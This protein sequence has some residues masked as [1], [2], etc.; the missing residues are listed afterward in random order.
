MNKFKSPGIIKGKITE[1]KM[2][3]YQELLMNP[4]K[5]KIEGKP[6]EVKIDLISCMCDNK[7]RWTIKKN[8]EGDYKINT[9]GYAYSNWQIDYYRDDIEW[10]CDEG[11]WS[12]VFKMINTGT[13]KIESIKYR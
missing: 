7:E 12:E 5:L 10:E 3:K 11:N 2:D 13:S 8:E 4:P 9:H 1:K 6:R